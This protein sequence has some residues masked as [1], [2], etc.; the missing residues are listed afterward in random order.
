MVLATII[1]LSTLS[2]SFDNWIASLISLVLFHAILLLR[3]I[4]QFPYPSR[5]SHRLILLLCFETLVPNTPVNV[6][7]LTELEVEKGHSDE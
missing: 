3:P 4:L 7:I 2:T 6:V 5:V 1:T